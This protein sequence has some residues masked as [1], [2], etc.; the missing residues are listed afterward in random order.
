M[1][2]ADKVCLVAAARPDDRYWLTGALTE[3][4]SALAPLSLRPTELFVRY[5]LEGLSRDG[6]WRHIVGATYRLEDRGAGPGRAPRARNAVRPCR[7]AGGRLAP[8]S[9]RPRQAVGA[10]RENPACWSLTAGVRLQTTRPLASPAK[11][12][13]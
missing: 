9:C 4:V 6:L 10:S 2:Y 3:A 11:E 7:S 8:L 1:D 13:A 12:E 5:I